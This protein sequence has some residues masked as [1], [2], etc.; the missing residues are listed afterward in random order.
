MG[1]DNVTFSSVEF[2]MEKGFLGSQLLDDGTQLCRHHGSWVRVILG[3]SGLFAF[4][5]GHFHVFQLQHTSWVCWLWR[6]CCYYVDVKFYVNFGSVLLA[7]NSIRTFFK[8]LKENFCFLKL[9]LS[10]FR[11]WEICFSHYFLS[12]LKYTKHSLIF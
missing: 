2:F 1:S 6:E 12:V 4:G 10:C 3:F 5:I 11:K 7:S 8:V 9:M